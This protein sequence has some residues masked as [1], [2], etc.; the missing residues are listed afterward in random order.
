[1]NDDPSMDRAQDD[2]VEV[3]VGDAAAPETSEGAAPSTGSDRAVADGAVLD[4]AH[5]A[6]VATRGGPSRHRV[7]RSI[8]RRPILIAIAVATAMV[9]GL[10]GTFTAMAK[11]VTIAVDGVGQQVTTLSGTVD[12]ALS[13][14]GLAV[15]THDVLAPA[16][17]ADISDG[18]RI[19][20]NRGRLFTVTVDGT[21]KSAWTTG[22]TVGEAMEQLGLSATD[23]E[24]SVDAAGKIPL[25]GLSVTANTLHSVTLSVEPAPTTL[26]PPAQTLATTNGAMQIPD[27][28]AGPEHLT[29]AARTVGDLLE[30]QGVSVGKDN[31]VT[32]SLSTLLAD[33]MA[34]TVSELPTLTVRVGTHEPFTVIAGAKTV[35]AMLAKQQVALGANDTVAPGPA[36]PL[37]DKMEVTVTRVTY[38]TSSKT[39]ALPQPADQKVNDGSLAKG[40]TKITQSGHAG[41]SEVT[42]RTKLVNGKAGEA[43]EVSRKTIVEAVPTVIHVGTYVAPVPKS[44]PS[45]SASGS[46]SSSAVSDPAPHSG[47][48]WDAIAQCESGQNWSINTGNGYYG[49]LQFDRSTWL[50]AGG[51]KYAPRADLATK[52]QQIDIANNL[53]ARRGLQPW[54]CARILGMI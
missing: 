3:S 12:G 52:A 17:T 5:A 53:Y 24:L 40:T 49:G 44:S 27:T 32:P 4:G 48:N 10:V 50:S 37:A 36:A 35:G 46:G 45:A 16:A 42:Y 43:Q 21:E 51:G 26:N 19:V 25:S 30:Q 28:Q 31:R 39:L 41:K 47:V 6:Q 1:M 9:A 14:A 8:P 18:S 23:F 20:L 11:T 13:A 15:G 33:G 7:G 54:S 2:D 34:V 22:S 38:T 29:T